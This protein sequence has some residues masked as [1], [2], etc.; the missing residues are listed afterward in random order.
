MKGEHCQQ[1]SLSVS[2]YLGPSIIKMATE[3]N[4]E[5]QHYNLNYNNLYKLKLGLE[6]TE[7]RPNPRIIYHLRADFNSTT[8]KTNIKKQKQKILVMEQNNLHLYNPHRCHQ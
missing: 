3:K 7:K 8:L 6:E 2:S 5:Y 1:S 4:L